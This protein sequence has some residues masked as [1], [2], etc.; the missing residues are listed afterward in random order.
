MNKILCILAAILFLTVLASAQKSKYI[1]L[2]YKAVES[3]KELFKGVVSNGG[4][5]VGNPKVKPNYVIDEYFTSNITMFWL[6]RAITFTPRGG[7]EEVEVKDVVS[8]PKIKEHQTVIFGDSEQCKKDGKPEPDLVGLANKLSARKKYVIL[9]A[10]RI[11][12]KAEKFIPVSIKG[13]TCKYSNV[14]PLM[15]LIQ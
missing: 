3:G 12:F 11:N 7:V 15:P 1:G 14:I 2:R 13:I 4:Y 10:W 8:M 5:V 9:R 6:V